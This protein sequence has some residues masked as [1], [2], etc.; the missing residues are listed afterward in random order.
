MLKIDFISDINKEN[1]DVLNY[2]EIDKFMVR[3]LWFSSLLLSIYAFGIFYFKPALIYPSPYS[4]RAISLSEALIVSSAALMTALVMTVL[5]GRFRNHYIY[6]FFMTNAT[7]IYAY[8]L[9][10]VTGGAIEAHFYFFIMLGLLV[11]YADWRL[12]WFAVIAVALHHAGLNFY[13]PQWVYFYGRND[14]A[15]SAH[16][17]LVIIMAVFTTHICEHMRK[18]MESLRIANKELGHKS[19]QLNKATVNLN[20]EVSKRTKELQAKIKEME[21]FTNVAV[22][23]EFRIAE[24]RKELAEMRKKGGDGGL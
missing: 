11:L 10:F 6:R 1:Y 9:V 20:K 21:K 8:L 7:M 4:W 2:K 12:G 13:E 19:S 24:L 23:R 22:G 18:S 14:I 3:V 5:K 16:A 17:L 15:F